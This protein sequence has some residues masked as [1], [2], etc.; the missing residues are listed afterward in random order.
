MSGNIQQEGNFLKGPV[1]TGALSAMGLLGLYFGILTMANSLGHAVDQFV[2]LWSWFSALILGFGIQV[3]L[4]SYNRRLLR[5]RHL[6]K[7]A[8]TK[9]ITATG[10]ISTT[11]MAAC[12]VHHLS[13]V[14]PVIGLTG[15][16]IFFSDYQKAFLLLGAL[17]NLVGITLMLHVM[18]KHGLTEI[19]HP[20]F[21]KI[22]RW[23]L[24]RVFR[25]NTGLSVAVFTVFVIIEFY[26]R[27]F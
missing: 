14:L 12:C 8:S 20:F 23:N 9:G 19:G 13:D 17:S 2:M 5:I 24:A 6:S 15:A 1:F 22:A 26:R 18:Q 11:A 21:E 3:G 10:G 7:T 4:Y 16:A 27:H 25:W